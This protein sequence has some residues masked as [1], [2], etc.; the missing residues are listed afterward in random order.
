M[1]QAMY[2]HVPFCRDICAYCDFTRCGYHH[3]LAQQW[4]KRM[5]KDIEA[6]PM[7]ELQTLYIGGG[8]PSALDV[9]QLRA[10]CQ[11]FQAHLHH[12]QEFSVEVNADSLSDE[13]IKVLVQSGV[14]RISMGAQAFN[15]QLLKRIQRKA[16][17]AMIKERIE[18]LC[19]AGITNIS[20]DLMYGL[21]GQTMAHWKQDLTLA[22]QLPITHISLYSLTIEE[23]SQFGREGVQPCDAELETDMFETAIHYLTTH[24]FEHYETSNFAKPGKRSM[25]NQMYW[26]YEDFYG[27]GCGASGKQD[28]QRYDN[29][30]NLHT[31]ITQ[32]ASPTQIALSQQDEMFEMLM[33]NLRLQEGIAYEDFEARFHT[34]LM[35]VYGNVIEKQ[36]Q[37]GYLREEAGHLRT[38]YAGMML[39]NEVLLEFL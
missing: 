39:L 9:D 13:K 22:L 21:P 16:D 5:L 11:P 19:K 25:H 24:G 31:Y 30:R 34:S 14:N 17:Y 7:D 35:D 38:T 29:T 18:A 4:L 26:H 36:I 1:T 37:R 32:G 23:H 6:C 12:I 28:H 2:I 3:G 33:M 8:T 10:L 20:L 15:N 27:I